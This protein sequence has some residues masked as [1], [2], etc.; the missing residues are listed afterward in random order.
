MA[1]V[2]GQKADLVKVKKSELGSL[3]LSFCSHR[4]CVNVNSCQEIQKQ[5]SLPDPLSFLD[6]VKMRF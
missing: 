2:V 3:K 6:V 4:H 5:S 1:Y